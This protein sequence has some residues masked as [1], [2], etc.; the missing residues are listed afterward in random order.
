MHAIE[1]KQPVHKI[2][3]PAVARVSYKIDFHVGRAE[4][5][6]SIPPDCNKGFRFDHFNES[7][8]KIGCGNAFYGSMTSVGKLITGFMWMKWKD[9]P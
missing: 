9:V 3:L 6:L 4:R 2:T 8:Q 1:T 7:R 5:L